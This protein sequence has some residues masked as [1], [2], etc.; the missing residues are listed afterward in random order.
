MYKLD[1]AY[2]ELLANYFTDEHIADKSMINFQDFLNIYFCGR[3][4]ERV[5]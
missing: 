1:D 4:Y 3:W 2:L 5:V